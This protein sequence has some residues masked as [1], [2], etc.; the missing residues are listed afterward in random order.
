MAKERAATPPP[1]EQVKRTL[2]MFWRTAAFSFEVVYREIQAASSGCPNPNRA[3]IWFVRGQR[4]GVAGQE[5]GGVGL[6]SAAQACSHASRR[7]A[8]KWTR[9]GDW[10]AGDHR[11]T[12]PRR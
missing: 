4:E 3:L 1:S 6:R 9:G 2:T 10:V 12:L 8:I 5:G 11:A 7:S